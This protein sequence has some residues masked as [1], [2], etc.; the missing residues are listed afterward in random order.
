MKGCERMKIIVD[1]EESCKEGESF[2][3]TAKDSKC[4]PFQLKV[5]FIS[6][7]YALSSVVTA[8]TGMSARHTSKKVVQLSRRLF[9]CNRAPSPY[10][11][12][13]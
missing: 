4:A 13:R 11:R 6:P 9:P 3:Q 7:N 8:S 1:L 10:S 2:I 12:P 5:I